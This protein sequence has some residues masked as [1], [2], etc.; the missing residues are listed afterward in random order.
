MTTAAK[1]REIAERILDQIDGMDDDEVIYTRPNTYDMNY[2][3]LETY[4]GF[5]DY[6]DI[7]TED[8]GEDGYW[9]CE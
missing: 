2:T 6:T 5:I 3:I 9:E 1:L 8:D 4:D 7:R